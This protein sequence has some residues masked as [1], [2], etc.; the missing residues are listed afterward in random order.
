MR[1]LVTGGTG[2]LGSHLVHGLLEEGFEVVVLKRTT[3]QTWRLNDVLSY[4]RLYNIEKMEQA[5]KDQHVDAVIH[6]ACSYGRS[7][8]PP[9]TIVETNILFGLK[10]IECATYF[11]T[12]T[13]IN[14]DTLLQKYL[15]FYSLSKKQF[16]E[17]L[18]QYSKQIQVISMR[19]E[20]MYGPKD[21]ETKFIP[22]LI[23]QLQQN[24]K[25]I[26]LTSGIQKR[27]FIYITD[28]VAAYLAVLKH[29]SSLDN[30]SEFDV[31]TG[32]L[33]SVKD[34]VTELVGRYK[35]MHSKNTTFLNFGA[36]PY[37]DGEMMNINVKIDNL[38]KLGWT[39]QVSYKVG[40]SNLLEAITK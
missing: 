13:F 19:L 33:V 40:I 24:S 31:G 3:S 4:I 1:I 21:D 16:T 14:T 11:N 29:K 34:F 30:F 17:W 5:F 35:H 25:A 36:R 39:P 10:V 6:T 2:F 26:P 23:S 32:E 7:M 28:V 38:T 15:N 9:S 18:K 20:H 8:E 27:D 22:W 12:D 37:R